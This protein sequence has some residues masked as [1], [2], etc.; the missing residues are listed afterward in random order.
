MVA[1]VIDQD[2]IAEGAKGYAVYPEE[3]F[4]PHAVRAQEQ[5]PPGKGIRHGEFPFEPTIGALPAPL[6]AFFN[7]LE[8]AG[9]RDRM[10]AA[11]G[12]IGAHG[13][14]P[15]LFKI[16]ALQGVFKALQLCEHPVDLPLIEHFP[17]PLPN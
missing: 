6:P 9:L 2:F 1:M 13:D 11:V 8:Q 14:L 5:I 12:G 17:L 4:I 10:V 16:I 15:D 7:R 3:R